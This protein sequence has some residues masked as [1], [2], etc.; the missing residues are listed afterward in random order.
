VA[1][2]YVTGEGLVSPA[3]A[4]GSAPASGTPIANLPK[5]QQAVSVT[6]GGVGAPV[7]FAGIPAGLVGV[8][9]INYQVPSS[10]A[11]G[12]QAVIVT[13]GGVSSQAAMLTV[14]P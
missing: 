1:T 13:V 4:T 6:V 10:V 5:P 7:Q 2:L 14:T 11:L 8:S 9:Q 3:I 12:S